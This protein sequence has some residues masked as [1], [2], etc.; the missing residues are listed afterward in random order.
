MSARLGRLLAVWLMFVPVAEPAVADEPSLIGEFGF[1]PVEVFKLSPRSGNLLSGDLNHDGRIDL[2]L[3]DNGQHRI[4]LLIQREDPSRPAETEA[5]GRAV[6]DLPQPGRFEHRKLPVDHEIASLA[7]GDFDHDGL[8]DLAYFGNPDQ[9]VIRYQPTQGDVWSRK[10]QLRIP[11]VSAAQWCLTA[12]DLNQD[13]RDDLVVLGKN[14]TTILLQTADGALSA[15]RRLLN[16]STKLGLVQIADIDGDGRH[17]LCYLAGEALAR[18]LAVRLQDDRGQLG[19][20]LSFDL[21]RPRAVSV[22]DIDGKPGHEI[23]LIDARTGRLKLLQF[24][25]KSSREGDIPGRLLRYGF[26][27][28]GFGRDRDLTLG[29]FDGNGLADV[30]VSDPEASQVLLFRQMPGRGL[31]LGVPFPAPSG[32]DIMRTAMFGPDQASTLVLHSTAERSIGVSEWDDGRLQFPVPLPL[33][34]EP[35]GLEL[36]NVTGD[37][38]PEV[39]FLTRDRESRESQYTLNGYRR[40]ADP[41]GWEPVTQPASLKLSLKGS[42]ERM[43]LAQLLGDDRPE[44]MIF[45]GSRPP[46]VVSLSAGGGWEVVAVSGALGSGSVPAGATF[47]CTWGEHAGLL[48]GQDNFARHLHLNPLRRWEVSDQVNAGESSAKIA[49]AV[50]LD[51]D[52]QPGDELVLIDGGVRKLRIF[53]RDNELFAPHKELDMGPLDF[54]SARVGD[55]NGDRR[56]DLL[57]FGADQFAVLMSAGS[58]AAVEEMASYETSLEKSFPSDVVAGDL[59]G[60]GRVDLALTDTRS[61]YLEVLDYRPP[62]KLSRGLYFT[63]FEEKGFSQDD[64]PGSDPREAHIADVTGDG[65][66][67]LILLTHDRVLVYPQDVVPVTVPKHAQPMKSRP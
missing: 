2:V 62:S 19:P 60:D 56:D 22:R 17:D 42:P 48:V 59:N 46:V 49:G 11:D 26:G 14:E 47:P 55:L 29:D 9:L 23:L 43:Q 18:S 54:K 4:D 34:V 51:L 6:N 65:R 12:G 1:L 15:P 3:V 36:W 31:D 20:E 53:R 63:V 21:E 41:A 25:M 28:R 50:L 27:Q 64:A 44:L 24:R 32:V 37:A 39:V 66:D 35:I 8:D 67:D 10:R 38:A 61:H 57:L 33:D 30:A 16:T 52:G 5:P 40:A 58:T 13:G 45:Q 7:V